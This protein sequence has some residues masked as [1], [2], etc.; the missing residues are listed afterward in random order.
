MSVIK[1]YMPADD[2]G[3]Q[4]WLNNFA[5]KINNYAALFNITAVDITQVQNDASDWSKMLAYQEA[6]KEYKHNVTTY[7]NHLNHTG[8]TTVVLT[9][10][11]L[12]PALPVFSSTIKADIFGRA[13]QMVQ[14]IK[15]NK[16]Y[17][18]NIGKDLGIIGAEPTPAPHTGGNLPTERAAELKPVLKIKLNKGG[19]PWIK[20]KKGQTHAL[21]IEVDRGDGKGFILLTIATHHTYT[22][23]FALPLINTTAIWKYR[24]IYLDNHEEQ[25]GQWS[26]LAQITVTG[27]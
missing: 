4:T 22:D 12:A 9:A 27:I 16:N 23:M 5:G 20:W 21:R 19:R 13:A 25:E 10:L 11:T 8:K 15:A 6:L 17:T 18:E 14:S 2:A 7:K 3:R 26:E 1:Y 24:G